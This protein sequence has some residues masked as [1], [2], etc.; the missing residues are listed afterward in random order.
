M[1]L[2]VGAEFLVRAA[3]SMA[4]RVG[5]SA[6]VIGL[7][8]VSI[9][10][11][12]PEL[13]VSL[14]AVLQ[15]KGAL[16][17]GNVV[18]SNISNIALILGLAALVQPLRV[19]AQVVRVDGPILVAVSVLLVLL[20]QDAGLDRVD[21]VLLSVG[22]VSYVAFNVWAAQ[23]EPDTVREE[24][25]TGV[26][27]Q[28][29]FW[30]DLVFFGFG[31]GGLIGGADLLVG[32]A[33]HVARVLELSQVVIGLTVVAVGTSLPELATSVLAAY[34]GSGDIAIG[35]AVGSSIFNILG[36][37]GV[38]AAIRP[39]STASL[40]I[41]ELVVM[42]GVAVLVLPLLRTHFTLSRQEGGVLLLA[43]VGYVTY[44]FVGV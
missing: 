42:V 4:R 23:G 9:G 15:G 16:S 35:N 19:E 20:I 34:R 7:T 3:A 6:L 2:T 44:L 39:L 18:G 33:V 29:A 5:L 22:V 10:T 30:R 21:G 14:D 13:V 24:Y 12:L 41:V 38:T 25:D 1:L 31:L 37:L 27:N 11:S 43:Y 28:H 26:P 8:V 40:S 17:I 36:I 32:G